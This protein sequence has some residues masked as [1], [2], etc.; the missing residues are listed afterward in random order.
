MVLLI[1]NKAKIL[2]NTTGEALHKRGYRDET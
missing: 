2:L 1:D